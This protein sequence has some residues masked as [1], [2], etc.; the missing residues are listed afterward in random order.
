[1]KKRRLPKVKVLIP[2]YTKTCTMSDYIIKFTQIN[3]LKAS[4]FRLNNVKVIL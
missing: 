2:K 1:M 4:F 3:H